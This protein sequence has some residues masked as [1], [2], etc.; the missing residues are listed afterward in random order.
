QV[1]FSLLFIMSVNAADW[2]AWTESP[3]SKCSG[4]CGYCGS[5]VFAERTCSVVGKCSGPSQRL[6]PC[7]AAMCRFPAQYTCCPGYIKGLLPAGTF[8]CVAVAKTVPHK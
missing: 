4:T 6:E 7:G 8:E 5:R 2:S 3:N 1:L